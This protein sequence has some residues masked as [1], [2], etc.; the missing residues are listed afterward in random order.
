M[1]QNAFRHV[2]IESIA[3]LD[4]CSDLRTHRVQLQVSHLPKYELHSVKGVA[5]TRSIEDRP[6]VFYPPHHK[7]LFQVG[8]WVSSIRQ[9]SMYLNVSGDPDFIEYSRPP[10]SQYNRCVSE[11]SAAR[12]VE[13][14]PQHKSGRLIDEERGF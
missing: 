4:I 12:M 14:V 10:S 9:L 5:I 11:I 2:P 1:Q 13:T 8:T 3:Q 6:M 7:R